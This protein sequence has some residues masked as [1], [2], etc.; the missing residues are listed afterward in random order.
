MKSFD[1]DLKKYSEK[2]RLK[3][4]ER[5]ELRERILSYMEYHPLPKKAESIPMGAI[6]SQQYVIWS[7]FQTMWA[8]VATGAFL[9]LLVVSVP[10]AA[11]RSVPGDALYLVKTEVNE[12]IQSQFANSPYEKVVFE[13]KLIER[14]IGEARLLASEGKLTVE[15]EAAIAETVQVHADAAQSGLA[16]LRTDNAEEAAIA[17]IAFGSALEVQSAVLD[18]N[19]SENATSSIGNILDV[20]NTTREQ[21]EQNKST[22]TPSYDSFRARIELETTRAFELFET[23]KKSATTEE[24]DDINRRLA[25]IDRKVIAAKE[26]QATDETG[27]VSELMNALGLLQ[28]L[29]AFMTD[30]DIRE[31]VALETL[32]PIVPTIEERTAGVLTSLEQVNGAMKLVEERLPLVVA[33]ELLEKVILGSEQV[34][35]LVYTATSSLNA[36]EIEV[37][38][39]SSKEALALALDLE[40]MTNTISVPQIPATSTVDTVPPTAT[41]TEAV[42][43]IVGTTTPEDAPEK[44]VE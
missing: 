10:F 39:N 42:V 3:A 16:E 38:E 7:P 41:T 1:T 24:Q 31:T 11:E 40:M 6:V 13:T 15:V 17:E 23:V 21:V 35:L 20:V 26:L 22:T 44:V 14:R 27:A 36:G 8:R 18:T 5:R 29:I 4:I 25:D 37:A 30:I 32:V 19:K 43:E 9:F 28:K 34:E 12:S 33:E 2:I